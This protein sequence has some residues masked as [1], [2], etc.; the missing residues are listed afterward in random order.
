MQGKVLP[1]PNAMT[2][3]YAGID[4]CKEW[5]DVDVPA[6]TTRLRVSNDPCGR[7]RLKRELARLGV[8]RVVMEATGKYH[9]AA[10][11]S[12]HAAG[13]AVALV[14]PLRAR[15]F[16]KACGYLAKTDRIDARLLALMG[17]ALEPTALPPPSEAL[18]DLQ[19]LVNARTAA[20]AERT[21]LT[22]RRT[23]AQTAFLRAELD[24][25][26]KAVKSHLER[27]D[28][29]IEKRIRTEPDL[30]RRYTIVTS[31]PGIG[32][33]TAAVLIANFAELGACSS[34]QA[35][36][37]AGV[38]PVACESGERIGHRAIK[39]GRMSVRNAI[40]MAALS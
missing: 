33:V 39:G 38:A 25:R 31:I 26:L 40:Y 15:L 11:R 3:V 4:V 24:R 7:R 27:L 2:A 23:A 35:A 22:N 6:R 1:E 9:R 37:L 28:T 13:F 14:D 5:L 17:E 32:A 12:L 8:T 34:K 36:M 19:E 21:A 18:L 30:A 10:Q 16:A 20:T 29:E